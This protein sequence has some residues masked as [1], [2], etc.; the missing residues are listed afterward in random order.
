MNKTLD[1]SWLDKQIA[2]TQKKL[3]K[4]LEKDPDILKPVN[5]VQYGKLLFRLGAFNEVKEKLKLL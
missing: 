1:E 2:A 4:I 3:D 5:K